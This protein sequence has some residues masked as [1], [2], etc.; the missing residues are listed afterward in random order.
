MDIQ[1]NRAIYENLAKVMQLAGMQANKA[2]AEEFFE[3]INQMTTQTLQALI[4][5]CTQE[6]VDRAK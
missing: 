1:T 2:N 5:A 4:V 6:L 3:N